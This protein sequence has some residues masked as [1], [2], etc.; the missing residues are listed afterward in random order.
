[1]MSYLLRGIDPRLWHRAKAK[2]AKERLTMR[3]VLISLLT[4]WVQA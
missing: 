1:M 2:A 4:K 3:A